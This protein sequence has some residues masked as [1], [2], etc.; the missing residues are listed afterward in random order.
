MFTYL[1][2]W[3]SGTCVSIVQHNILEKGRMLWHSL[4]SLTSTNSNI[5]SSDKFNRYSLLFCYLLS[6]VNC[7]LL[8][9]VNTGPKVLDSS[10]SDASF[11]AECCTKLCICTTFF[12]CCSRFW[13]RLLI[14]LI[15][16]SL[17]LLTT[18]NLSC[19]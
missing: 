17:N 1:L 7:Y 10:T 9:Y 8:S 4:E 6:Y 14:L 3:L 15:S 5:S 16:D 11:F 12:D 18:Q 2:L 13:L 19:V